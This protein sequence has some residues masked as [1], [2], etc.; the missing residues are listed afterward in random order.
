LTTSQ[1]HPSNDD[2]LKTAQDAADRLALALEDVGFDVGTAFPL[3]TVGTAPSG[4]P[5]VRLGNVTVKVASNLVA[6]LLEAA[7]RGVALG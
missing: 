1:N 7:R 6:V 5:I 2:A 3:L 4:E